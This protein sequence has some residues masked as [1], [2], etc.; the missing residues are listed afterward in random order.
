MIKYLSCLVVLLCGQFAQASWPPPN[1]TP[2][3]LRKD[4]MELEKILNLQT[5]GDEIVFVSIS[6]YKICAG[7]QV[8]KN[9]IAIKSNC[10]KSYKGQSAVYK[11]KTGSKGYEFSNVEAFK[12]SS[13][14]NQIA[15]LKLF[16]ELSFDNMSFGQTAKDNQLINW[17]KSVANQRWTFPE[18]KLSKD[19]KTFKKMRLSATNAGKIMLTFHRE[20]QA[21]CNHFGL[22]ID[23]LLDQSGKVNLDRENNLEY[24]DSI[25]FVNAITMG[26]RMGCPS[27][28]TRR[29][30]ISSKPVVLIPP[31]VVGIK[32]I[33]SLEIVLPE[34]VTVKVEAQD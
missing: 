27:S 26:T 19:E 31:K 15:L 21:D 24:S 33:F 7:L 32:S 16:E 5:P 22:E 29:I 11:F 18:T 8:A 2:E 23:M 10:D 9:L 6:G 20:I 4:V 1:K 34:D 30:T 13:G 25:A 28:T 12:I 14:Q 3:E 17:I